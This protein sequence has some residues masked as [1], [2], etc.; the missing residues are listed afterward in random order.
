MGSCFFLILALG[1]AADA[2]K[3]PLMDKWKPAFDPK[4]AQYKCLVSNV[5]RPVMRGSYAGFIICDELWLRTNGQIYFDF[6]PLLVWVQAFWR[7][8]FFSP[9][10]LI[11]K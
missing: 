7:E 1:T 3:K 8:Q 9:P 2:K 4:G 11:V 10:P 5:G 6:K